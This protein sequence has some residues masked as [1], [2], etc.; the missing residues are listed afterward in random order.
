MAKAV[1]GIGTSHSPQI[2]SGT[3]WWAGHAERDLRNTFLVAEDGSVRGFEEMAAGN[4]TQFAAQLKPEVWEAKDAR[5]QQAVASLTRQLSEAAPDV[6]VIVGDD[7]RELY[8]DD[9]NPAIGLFVGD[10]LVDAG[11]TAERRARMPKDILPAQWAAH[12]DEADAYPVAADLSVHLAEEL[13]VA[14][15]DLGVFSRQ[16]P[17]RSLG[18]AFT[19]PRRRLGLSRDVPIVPLTINT[20]YG[21]NVPTPGRCWD[22]GAALRAALDSWHDS[23]TVAL[24]A[25]GG[26]SHFVISEELDTGV[27]DAL[28]KADRDVIAGIPREVLRSGNSEILNWIVVGGALSDCDFQVADYIPAYRS[29]AGTGVGMAFAAWRP[30]GSEDAVSG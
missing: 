16:T 18:H 9:V 11:L 3:G 17:G 25:S 30:R 27:L 26:L 14:G 21:P 10:E 24:V 2:S 19:F 15:F 5:A 6:V 22:L 12:A 8:E 1:L 20:Y 28:G 7:Q 4:G 29:L 13:S 23:R